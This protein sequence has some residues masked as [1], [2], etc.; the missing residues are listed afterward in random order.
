MKKVE[1]WSVELPFSSGQEQEG[2]RPAVIFADTEIGIVAV[3]PLTSNLQALRFKHTYT[4]EKSKSNGLIADSVAL[5]FQLRAIDSK[6][7]KKK[8]GDLESKHINNLNGLIVKYLNL[9]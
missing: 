9:Q 4:I 6:R 3:I 1:M 2:L 5:I 8:I 7:L